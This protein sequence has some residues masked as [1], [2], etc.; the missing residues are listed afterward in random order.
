MR[1]GEVKDMR[2]KFMKKLT[3]TNIIGKEM[4]LINTKKKLLDLN[5]DKS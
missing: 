1:N 5:L 2:F 3:F 4:V